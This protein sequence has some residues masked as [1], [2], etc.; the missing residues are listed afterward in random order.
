MTSAK[1]KAT[2]A[3]SILTLAKL[4]LGDRAIITRIEMPEKQIARLAAR[5]IVPGTSIGVIRSGDPVLIG[6]DDDRWAI[7]QNEAAAIHV[8]QLEPARRGIRAL[9]GR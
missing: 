9:F 3:A 8:E 7:E 4:K 5:G 1:L 2:T 6:V